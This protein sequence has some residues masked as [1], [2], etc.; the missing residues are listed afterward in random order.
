MYEKEILYFCIF[1]PHIA[2]CVGK[3]RVMSVKKFSASFFS[4][5]SAA[6]ILAKIEVF[7]PATSTCREIFTQRV[8]ILWMTFVTFLLKEK[9][10]LNFQQKSPEKIGTLFEAYF[11]SSSFFSPSTS[12]S[13]TSGS[14]SFFGSAPSAAVPSAPGCGCAAA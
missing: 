6:G 8:I 11:F 9:L 4:R 12:A 7:A 1:S 14:P 3:R 13:F 2:Q 5:K 10:T